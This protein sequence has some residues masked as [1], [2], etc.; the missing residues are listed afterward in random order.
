MGLCSFV[1]VWG[2]IGSANFMASFYL[3]LLH[4][5]T[6]KMHKVPPFALA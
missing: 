6:K 1:V 3:D 2:V 5:S 4:V